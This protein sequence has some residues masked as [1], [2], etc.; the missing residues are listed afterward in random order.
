MSNHGY[1]RYLIVKSAN[2][3]DLVI[4]L[5]KIYNVIPLDNIEETRLVPNICIIIW[6]KLHEIIHPGRWYWAK[7]NCRLPAIYFKNKEIESD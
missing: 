7:D 2:C 4:T 5:Q 1:G 3:M 6:P